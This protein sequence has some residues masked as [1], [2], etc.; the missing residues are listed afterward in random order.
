MSINATT[1]DGAITA[2]QTT[3]KLASGTGA[4]VKKFIRIDDEFLV[5]QGID[6][7]PLLEV[8]RGQNGSAAVAHVTGAAAYI[9][10][11]SDFPPIPASRQY[12]YSAAGAITKAPGLHILA[13][14]AA[15]AMTLA[16]P[17]GADEGMRLVIVAGAAQAYTVAG[18]FNGGG[19]SADLMTFGGAIGDAFE[20]VARGSAWYIL[21][22]KN[23][24]LS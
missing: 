24:T 7:S 19:G 5:I 9:G 10:L 1:L 21:D 18:T 3:V 2:G 8:M 17:T 11:A 6:N 12:T 23:V 20:V 4:V 16:A 15:N 14:G 13:G 22:S